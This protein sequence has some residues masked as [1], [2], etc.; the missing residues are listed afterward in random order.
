MAVRPHNVRVQQYPPHT[1]EV[2][3]K[4]ASGYLKPS[5]VLT[6]A[7]AAFF[8]HTRIIQLNF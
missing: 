2:R 6:P 1:H 7:D 8:L 5:T 4:T 3:S